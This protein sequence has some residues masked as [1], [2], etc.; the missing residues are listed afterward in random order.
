MTV[1]GRKGSPVATIHNPAATVNPV[2]LRVLG[3][4]SGVQKSGAGYTARCPAHDDRLASLSIGEGSDGR[5]LLHCFAGCTIH[6]ILAG[7]RLQLC[8]LFIERRRRRHG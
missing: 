7:L 8:D 2:V 5:A 6:D 3:R 1:P 4:L